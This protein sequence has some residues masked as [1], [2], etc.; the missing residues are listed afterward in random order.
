MFAWLKIAYTTESHY[1]MCATLLSYL[2]ACTIKDAKH[3]A[4]REAA[5]EQH[6][7]IGTV[8]NNHIYLIS[9]CTN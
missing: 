5:N 9:A 7:Q 4:I 2:N 3:L 6:Q 1:E 8:E